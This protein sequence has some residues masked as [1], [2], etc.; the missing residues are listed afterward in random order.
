[1]SRYMAPGTKVYIRDVDPY[2]LVGRKHHPPTGKTSSGLEKSPISGKKGYVV[3]YEGWDNADGDFILRET[4]VDT[5]KGSAPEL[6]MDH[7]IEEVPEA[8]IYSKARISHDE[9]ALTDPDL[10]PTHYYYIVVPGYGAYQ[11]ADYE[12][13]GDM[14]WPRLKLSGLMSGMRRRLRRARKVIAAVS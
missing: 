11:F 7:Y 8:A 5:W 9:Y 1:M 14:S 13:E 12:I 10:P 4:D 3:H 2:G 6:F